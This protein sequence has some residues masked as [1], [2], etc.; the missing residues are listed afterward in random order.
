MRAVS[1]SS[2]STLQSL[3]RSHPRCD[4]SI[5]RFFGTMINDQIDFLREAISLVWMDGV[6]GVGGVDGEWCVWCVGGVGG[7]GGV[8]GTGG[9]W[10]V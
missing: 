6:G 10:V 2:F 7:V 3:L 4:R 9:V 8:D 1:K 5:F